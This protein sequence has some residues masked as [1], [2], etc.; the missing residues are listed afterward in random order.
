[1]DQEPEWADTGGP[2]LPSGEVNEAFWERNREITWGGVKDG[3]CGYWFEDVPLDSWGFKYSQNGNRYVAM[4]PEAIAAFGH[5]WHPEHERHLRT[6]V[7]HMGCFGNRFVAL[8]N[9]GEL[10]RNYNPEFYRTMLRRYRALEQEVGCG[11]IAMVGTSVHELFGEVD[12]TITHDRAPLLAPIG[13]RWTINNEHNPHFAPAEEASYFKQARERHLAWA[14]WRAGQS[15]AEYA[16]TMRLVKGIVESEAPTVC[17]APPAQPPEDWSAPS[18][19]GVPTYSPGVRRSQLWVAFADAKLVVG[20]RCGARGADGS[21]FQGCLETNALIAAEL[22][23][24]GFCASGP[25][26]D[27]TAAKAP[28]GK[29]EEWHVCSYGDGC[30]TATPYKGAWDYLR[31]TPPTP[32]CSN[33]APIPLSRWGVKEHIKGANKTIVDSTPLV[34]PDAA[35]CASVGF[36]DGRSVCAVRQEGDPARPSCEAQIVGTPQWTG[37]GRISPENIYQ[38]WVDRG[39]SGTAKVCAS[40]APTVCGSVEV[41]P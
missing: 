9:E 8:D 25:W 29:Y 30:Y 4:S 39:V 34:G 23:Q 26:G 38:Y 21:I 6:Y 37:P 28:D 7:E 27:A 33:P 36:T 17:F 40:A 13:G 22:R 12:Y 1:V 20:N 2:Y 24:R 15:D 16:E 14:L 5:T 19:P 18:A 31:E 10:V 41:T 11:F 35:Y 32:S 3:G